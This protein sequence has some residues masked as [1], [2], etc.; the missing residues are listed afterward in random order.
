MP[1]AEALAIAGSVA[2]IITAFK[3]AREMFGKWKKK[4]RRRKGFSSYEDGGC[5][6]SYEQSLNTGGSLIKRD[7]DTHYARL[8][9]AFARGDGEK[10]LFHS[11]RPRATNIIHTH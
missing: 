10:S 1:I 9:P 8:G 3:E 7:Y 4:R 5:P 2:A 6:D 11:T